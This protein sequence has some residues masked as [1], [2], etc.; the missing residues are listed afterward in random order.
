MRSALVIFPQTHRAACWPGAGAL[1]GAGTNRVLSRGE[2]RDSR[3]LLQPCFAGRKTASGEPMTKLFTAAHATLR[4]E[5][6]CGSPP[7]AGLPWRCG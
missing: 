4:W 2:R 7:T 6:S 5:P 1:R 3:Q